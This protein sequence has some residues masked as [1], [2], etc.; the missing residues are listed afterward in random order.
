M[1][2]QMKT[3]AKATPMMAPLDRSCGGANPELFT[4][5][6]IRLII[7]NVFEILKKVRAA[8]TAIL[9]FQRY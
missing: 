4:P 6:D 5:V 3:P 7:Q 9:I 1:T 2:R 8:E